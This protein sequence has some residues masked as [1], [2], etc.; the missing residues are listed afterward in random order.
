MF[1]CLLA[2][3]TYRAQSSVHLQVLTQVNLVL[4]VMEIRQVDGIFQTPVLH[5][6]SV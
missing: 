4:V 2:A 3:V 5:Q 1:C 6:G